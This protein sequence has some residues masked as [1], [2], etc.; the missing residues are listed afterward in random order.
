MPLPFFSLITGTIG[1]RRELTTFLASLKE[2]SF[3]N[4]EVILVDQNDT[5]LIDDIVDDFSKHISITHMREKRGLS[6]ARNIGLKLAKGS[7]CAFPDD[8]C[9]YPS[10]LLSETRSLIEE[11][12]A[13][14]AISTLVTDFYGKLSAG[15]FMAKSK[16]CVTRANVWRCAVSPSLF[17]KADC[18]NT[19]NGFDEMLGVG[20][21]TPWGSGEE[22]DMLLSM[23]NRRYRIE[24]VPTL[25]VFHPRFE[26]PWTEN[27]WNRGFA[28]GCGVGYVL[29]KHGY[30]LHHALWHAS[31]QL[32]KGIL[33]M[34]LFQWSRGRFHWLMGLGRLT[35][36]FQQR[37]LEEE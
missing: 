19:I 10:N 31:L 14:D 33:L 22:T 34:G 26:G 18:L 29:G 5:P 37:K 32:V 16:Q 8:D 24:Y 1:R 20:A 11:N 21:G 12:P 28:Y 4:F 6:R 2:H 23:I 9:H 36:Y 30:Q 13:W 3:K 15:G 27:S 25:T 35:G 17:I 7:W